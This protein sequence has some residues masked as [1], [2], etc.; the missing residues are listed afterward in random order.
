M[1][2]IAEYRFILTLSVATALCACWQAKSPADDNLEFFEKRIRPI[3]VDRC[4]SCHSAATGKT[5]GNLALDT[6]DGWQKGG[7]S[8]TAV[9]PGMPEDSLLIQAVRY[10]DDGPQMP[11]TE[12]GGKRPRPK[13]SSWWNG[14]VV[15]PRT[16]EPP[17][18]AL[19]G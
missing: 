9:V 7:D 15:A 13:S 19:A 18:L 8:G 12:K 5:S 16:L 4:E 6:R 10:T 2:C 3:L 14:C 17:W 1:I 11:P